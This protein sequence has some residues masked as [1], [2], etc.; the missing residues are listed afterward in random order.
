MEGDKVGE[1]QTILRQRAVD[2]ENSH[3][4]VCW[5]PESLLVRA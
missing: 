5:G 3:N 4:G 2:V 1:G